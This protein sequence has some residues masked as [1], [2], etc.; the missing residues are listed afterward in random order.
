MEVRNVA[1]VFHD[2]KQ[3]GA[4]YENNNLSTPSN[5]LMTY[6]QGVGSNY[7]H[8]NTLSRAIFAKR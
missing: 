8:L 5:R 6:I 7:S 4:S 2:F 3:R 1:S